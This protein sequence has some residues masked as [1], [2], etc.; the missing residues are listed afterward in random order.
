MLRKTARL[1]VPFFIMKICIPVPVLSD[2]ESKWLY[3]A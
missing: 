1:G 2:E 3:A